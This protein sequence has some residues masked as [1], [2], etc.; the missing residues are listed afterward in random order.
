[1]P[2]KLTLHP[3][4]RASRFVI[5]RPTRAVLIGRDPA[6]DLVLEDPRVSKRHARL[7]PDRVEDRVEDRVGDRVGE[8]GAA[9]VETWLL[10]DLGSKNGTTVNG[11]PAILLN[12]RDGDWISLGG[13]VAR[14]E[15]ISEEAAAALYHDRLRRLQ[16]TVEMRH[17]LSADLDPC[18]L[19]LRFLESA[20]QLTGT[21]RG[22][23]LAAS[24]SEPIRA[25]V[26]T[27][28]TTDVVEDAAFDG[29]V[30]VVNKVLRTVT[31]IVVSDVQQDAFLASRPSL[32]A[33]GIRT[34]ACVPLRQDDRLLG[35][36]Y[37]DGRKPGPGFTE[38]DLEILEALAEQMA[39]VLASARLES[40]VRELASPMAHG[41]GDDPSLLETLQ[42]RVRSV[43]ITR[44][45]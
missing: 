12:L 23:V 40:T 17:R 13:L 32:I 34:L 24:P 18:D 45:R 9:G 8:S 1:M 36:L 42:Q 39:L 29:S 26:S 19:L 21:E 22:F 4:E 3:P 10:E 2:A 14:F 31:S 16:T 44:T 30:G 28:F 7:R 33:L 27:G 41:T 37:V 11:L 43:T 25:L 15:M 20:V 38:L 6:V 5:L 35:V